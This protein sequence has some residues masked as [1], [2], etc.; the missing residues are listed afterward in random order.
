MKKGLVNIPTGSLFQLHFQFMAV[1]VMFVGFVLIKTYLL[2]S[3]CLF[4][5]GVFILSG[6]SGIQIDTTNKLYREYLSFYFM[7]W[8][9]FNSFEHIQKIFINSTRVTRTMYAPR[10]NHSASFTDR[11][12]N[13]FLKFDDGTKLLIVS[14]GNKDRLLRNVKLINAQLKTNIVDQ[15]TEVVS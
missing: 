8:G 4:A 3:I 7:K 13:A 15:T 6:R 10:S 12:Y 9:A 11:K 2:V 14:K 1:V 5:V